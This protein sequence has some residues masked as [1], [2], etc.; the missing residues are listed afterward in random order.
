MTL[1][2]ADEDRMLILQDSIQITI[3]DYEKDIDAFLKSVS[4]ETG[5]AQKAQIEA[6]GAYQEFL[7]EFDRRAAILQI[8]SISDATHLFL[9]LPEITIHKKVP[10]TKAELSRLTFSALQSIEAQSSSSQQKL[11]ALYDVL[12]K[13]VRQALID[14]KVEVVMLNLDGFIRYVPFAALY[15]GEKYLIEDFALALYTPAVPTKFVRGKRRSKRSAGFGVTCCTSGLFCPSR[16]KKR[17]R[18]LYSNRQK[19]KAF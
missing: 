11:K 15:D 13:P 9:T 18:R 1:S 19:Q 16:C 2:A 5:D 4:N 14:S 8:A 6:S 10:I 17:T 7:S 3:D 12:I